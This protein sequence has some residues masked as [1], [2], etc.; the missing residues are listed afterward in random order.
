MKA[1]EYRNIN[2]HGY[3]TTFRL[4][5]FEVPLSFPEVEGI[6]MATLATL[7]RA[8]PEIWLNANVESCAFIPSFYK[9]K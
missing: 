4:D 5:L 1:I 2:A 6:C 8:S 9:S 3:D 7:C